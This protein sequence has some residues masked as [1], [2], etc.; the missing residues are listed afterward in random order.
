[1]ESWTI[2][3][4]DCWWIDAFKL[5]S[6]R[7]LR[8]NRIA[9]RS[10]QSILKDWC[11]SWSAI[12]WPSDS[13]EKPRMLEKIE[14]RRTTEWQRQTWLDGITDSMDMSLSKLW[15]L[16]KDREAWHAAVHGV[17]KSQTQLSNWTTTS[18]KEPAYQCRRHKRCG[19]DFWVG[20]I[21]WRRAWKSTPVF[22][23]GESLNRGA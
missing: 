17:S 16:V 15:E 8:V 10:N 4:A 3:K 14:G 2:K 21:P 6:W 18:G 13:L 19:F 9:T 22:L 1:M 7:L 23:P 12:L 11:W 20:K 5:W